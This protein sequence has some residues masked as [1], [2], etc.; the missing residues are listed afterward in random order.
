MKHEKEREKKRKHTQKE[1]KKN[2]KLTFLLSIAV[3]QEIL[4]R[5]FSVINC[6]IKHN[7]LSCEFGRNLHL[8]KMCSGEIFR[9][10]IFSAPMECS[11]CYLNNLTNF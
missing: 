1:K 11:K 9:A 8:K 10:Q 3:K 4:K 7:N 6:L 5:T 2:R